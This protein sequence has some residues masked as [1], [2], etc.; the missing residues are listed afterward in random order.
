MQ[1]FPTQFCQLISITG[2]LHYQSRQFIENIE[3]DKNLV[4]HT[5]SC[6]DNFEKQASKFLQ[7]NAFPMKLA[8]HTKI[9]NVRY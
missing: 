2:Q 3:L 8:R 9:Y 7:G 6:I 5:L 1:A 4:L